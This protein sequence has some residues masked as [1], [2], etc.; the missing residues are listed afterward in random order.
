M[1]PPQP[2][3]QRFLWG[4]ATSAF[5]TEG[6]R[7][8]G[9]R[10]DSIWDEFADA[11]RVP[12][13]DLLGCDHYHRWEEDLDLLAALGVGAFRFSVS[14]PRVIPDG[15]GDPNP[16]GIRFYRNLVEGLRERGISP[17]LTLYHWDLPASLQ[18]DG[19]WANRETVEWFDRYADLLAAEL[20]ES[21]DYWITQN[22]PW[23]SAMLGHLEG[24]FA[25]GLRDWDTALRAGHHL[26]LSHGKAARSIKD[27]LPEASVGIALDCRPGYPASD[28]EPDLEATRHFDGFRNRWFFDPVF[29]KGYPNDVVDT[30]R[31]RGRLGKGLEDFVLGDD[32]E[33]IASP[34]DF[35]GLNYYTTID[36][37][38]GADELDT[39]AVEPGPNPPDG[40]TEMGWRNDPVGLHRY[41]HHIDD[42][43]R[44]PSVLITENGA[45][46]SEGPDERGRI[47]DQK[48][49][50]YLDAHIEA[51]AK[52][53]AEGV[54]VDG[55][56]VWSLLDN[57][58]WTSGYGQRFGLVWVDHTTGERIPKDS[59]AWYS[60][61]VR[62]SP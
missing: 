60:S 2:A 16:E 29:G 6:A 54:P 23:V 12:G 37:S 36:V 43:Y 46:F 19:G 33:V 53:R 4:A 26:L 32:L 44:P 10:G 13:F 25:P 57:L 31:R 51:I 27:R 11:G 52:A 7:R 48:R 61:R 8:E 18:K 21:V 9:G 40:H 45:S 55:Y 15:S 34:I 22:E 30:F 56:F 50:D 42:T 38:A 41:L 62:E 59:F 28:S 35:L 20:G 14:W 5:Q 3:R 49:I 58:E 47:R 1:A 24:V 39:P 17:A